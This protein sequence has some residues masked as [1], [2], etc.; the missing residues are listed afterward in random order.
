MCA[1]LTVE[2]LTRH[3]HALFDTRLQLCPDAQRAQT[4]IAAAYAEFRRDSF[5]Q[6]NLRALVSRIV[7]PD[8]F[9]RVGRQLFQTPIET[10]VGLLFN[11]SLIVPGRDQP[12]YRRT[13]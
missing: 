6:A 5:T 10:N 7:L 2:L 9:A 1:L 4:E 3:F 8:D 13:S 12:G 11:F